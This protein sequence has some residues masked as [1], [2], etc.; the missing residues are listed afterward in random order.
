MMSITPIK[1]ASNAA[2]YYLGEENKQELPDV[3]L[4]KSGENYYLREK[5][6]EENTFWHGSLVSAP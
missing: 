4:E 1:S 3:S 5:S 2:Q 6:Q